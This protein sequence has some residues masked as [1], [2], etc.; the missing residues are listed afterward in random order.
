MSL[1]SGAIIAPRSYR[2]TR[3]VIPG[4]RKTWG[5]LLVEEVRDVGMDGEFLGKPVDFFL[6]DE[7]HL[8]L[9]DLLV[10]LLIVIVVAFWIT[11]SY[12]PVFY[13]F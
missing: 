2:G 12:L 13:V 7:L 6:A 3:P 4:P 1:Y 9:G 11:N 8:A 10:K 5:E